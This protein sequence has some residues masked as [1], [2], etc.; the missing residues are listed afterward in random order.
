MKSPDRT[1]AIPEAAVSRSVASLFTAH[2]ATVGETYLQHLHSAAKFS[3]LMFCGAAACLVHAV[4]P[5]AFVRTGSSM[6]ER[7]HHMMITARA[8]HAGGK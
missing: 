7:L 2:P 5:F 8:R 1:S 6:I 3:V 4:L